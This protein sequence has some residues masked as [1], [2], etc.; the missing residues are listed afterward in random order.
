[1]ATNAN[2]RHGVPIK[3]PDEAKTARLSED[4]NDEW[5]PMP[6]VPAG[7]QRKWHFAVLRKLAGRPVR[8]RFRASRNAIFAVQ[9]IRSHSVNRPYRTIPRALPE[10]NSTSGASSGASRDASSSA[11]RAASSDSPLR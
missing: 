2:G 7:L 11:S 3:A 10:M 6:P 4:G 9:R 8:L 1:M 5:H